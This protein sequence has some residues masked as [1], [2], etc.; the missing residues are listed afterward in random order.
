MNKMLNAWKAGW[1]ME[2][3][4]KWKEVREGEKDTNMPGKQ[5]E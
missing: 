2:V 1:L 4:C 5:D 3:I